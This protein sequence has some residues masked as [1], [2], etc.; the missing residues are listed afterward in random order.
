METQTITS[1][2]MRILELNSEYFG[3]TRLQLMENAGHAIAQEIITRFPS[4]TTPIT[5][6]CGLG[7]NGGDGLVAARHLAYAKYDITILL[8]GK[9]ENITDA[10][11]QKNWIALKSIQHQIKLHEIH[12]SSFIPRIEGKVIVDALL[13]IGVKNAPRPPIAQLIQKINES[14][15]FRVAV[16]IPSGINPDTGE[17]LGETAVKANLTITF[18]KKKPGLEKA[19]NYVGELI[20]KN[21]GLPNEYEQLAGPGDVKSATKPRPKESR[22]GD[23]GKLL[24][25]GGSEVYSGA[26]TLAGLA[27]LRT[28]V[29]LAYIACPEKTAYTIAAISP[30]LITIKL[31]GEHLNPTNIPQIKPY[32]ESATAIILGPGLGLHKE[33]RDTTLE[34][35]RL[36]EEFKKPLLLD[37]DALKIF[38]EFKHALQ[39]P[40]VVTPHAGEYKILIKRDAPKNLKEKTEDVR[41]VAEE[42][43]AVILLKGAV[44]I[45]S[46]GK[47]IKLNFTGNPGMTVGGT[48]D[49]L[50]GI[51]G[52]LLA[53]G[54]ESFRAAVAG[55]FINGACGDFAYKDK[56]SHLV[57]TDLIKWIPKVMV[58]PMS[59]LRVRTSVP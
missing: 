14:E 8:A 58:D 57:P 43:N 46:D 47:R 23:F 12:D 16:D 4:E 50:S 1:E 39:T 40:S 19:T 22:K 32:I 25:I 33:T 55:A 37:A 54:V 6:V 34:L 15:A 44:D 45:I 30:N 36:I 51:V 26:P 59:H 49:V 7:G 3:V 29:D 17:L 48:G 56:G 41:Q 2:D 35:I 9:A 31:E 52:A 27:A 11:T 21:I 28:G 18:H 53:Q 38:A 24:I 13:G 42:L 20:V 10:N 5:I